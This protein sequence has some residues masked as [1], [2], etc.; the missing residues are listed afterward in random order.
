MAVNPMQ[1]KARNSF[2]LGML[3]TALIAAVIIIFLFL[4]LNTIKQKQEQTTKTVYVLNK[5]INSGDTITVSDLTP[6]DVSSD[7]VPVDFAGINNISSDTIARIS[8]K[9]GTVLTQSMLNTQGEK[10]SK[11]QR[12]Q[13]FNMITLPTQLSVGDY[14]DIRFMLPSGQDFVVVSKKKIQNANSTTIWINLTEEEILVMNSA[15]V[16]SYVITASKLYAVP[17]SEPGNQE[18]AMATYVPNQEVIS[19]INSEKANSIITEL[20]NRYAQEF[21]ERRN[22]NI[23]SALNQ[24]SDSELTNKESKIQEEITKLQESRKQYLDTLSSAR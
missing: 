17:Y 15:I 8:L 19:L 24:Y 14:V 10:V 18:T 2:L 1:R 11:D 9:S 16:E 21:V 3:V 13:E 12:L 5:N 6:T 20:S 4:Q 22:A 23:N 7:A